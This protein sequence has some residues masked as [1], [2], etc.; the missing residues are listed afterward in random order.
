MTRVNVKVMPNARKDEVSQDG[1]TVVVRTTA[2]PDKG[3]ANRAVVKL[4]SKHFKA[5]VFL[6][7]G[8]KSHDKVFE[9]LP[10]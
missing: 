8:E 2:P 7:S 5:K 3:R 10:K 1:E 6:V 4:L 9:I